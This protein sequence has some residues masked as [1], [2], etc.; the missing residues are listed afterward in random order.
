MKANVLVSLL[1]FE[2]VVFLSLLKTNVTAAYFDPLCAL[3][4]GPNIHR[5]KDYLPLLACRP[6][7]F[8]LRLNHH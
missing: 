7:F 2:H 4:Q 5:P 6:E 1:K 8:V 3:R